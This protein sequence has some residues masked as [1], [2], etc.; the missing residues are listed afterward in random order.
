M[1]KQVKL[2]GGIETLF[3]TL[4]ENLRLLESSLGLTAHL[5]ED[6]LEIEGEPSNVERMERI[7][8]DYSQL[9]REGLTFNNGDL[10]GYLKVAAEDPS[11]SLRSLVMTGRQRAFGKKSVIPKSPNQRTYLDA[12]DA[13]DMVFGVG[14]AGTGKTYLAVGMGIS[15]LLARKVSR[16]ILARPA[17]EAGERLGFLPGTIQEKVDPY[18]RPLY[19]ALYD[20]LETDKVERFL[21][22]GS[23]EIAPIAF[24]RGRTLNDSFV[25]LDEAQNT[26][27]E[28][29]KMFLTRMGFNSKAV[30]TGDVTQIDLPDGRRSGL[31]TAI[32]VLRQVQGISFVYFSEK[33]VVRHYL[34]QRIIRAYEKYEQNGSGPLFASVPGPSASAP[35]GP[36]VPE[37]NKPGNTAP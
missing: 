13:Y 16:I 35:A 31:L 11:H 25:I 24:M 6:S 21:E 14:P 2:S 20:L 37:Q 22:R 34:V 32:D 29:M 18:L 19:D 9:L 1:I 28:Q 17:V 8:E 3:G 33:D 5:K 36:S 23:I 4:D 7:L 27:G 30:I 12:I 15:Y 26:T 10:R